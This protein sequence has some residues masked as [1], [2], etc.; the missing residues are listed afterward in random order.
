MTFH[1]R[2][3]TTPESWTCPQKSWAHR[4]IGS[5][6]SRP[7]CLVGESGARYVNKA[8]G[9]VAQDSLLTR[10]EGDNPALVRFELHRLSVSTPRYSLPTFSRAFQWRDIDRVVDE[11]CGSPFG[12]TQAGLRPHPQRYRCR[13]PATHRRTARERCRHRRRYGTGRPR[14]ITRVLETVLARSRYRC[15]DRVGP[16]RRTPTSTVDNFRRL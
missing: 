16:D 10:G 6:T 7:G 9:R 13:D 8:R 15:E 2:R 11:R 3:F 12:R 14:A 1:P 5:T 4:R